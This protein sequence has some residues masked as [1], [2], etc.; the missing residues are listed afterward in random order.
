MRNALSIIIIFVTIVVVAI[1]VGNA[2][3]DMTTEHNNNIQN[4][5]SLL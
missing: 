1:L 5:I 4:A 2:L 3:V